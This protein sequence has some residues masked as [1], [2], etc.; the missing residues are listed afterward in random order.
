VLNY[1]LLN[2]AKGRQQI[3]LKFLHHQ[4]KLHHHHQE[5]QQSPPQKPPK[6]GPNN[7]AVPITSLLAALPLAPTSSSR[8]GIRF[9]YLIAF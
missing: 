5:G 9:C 4:P 6:F 2:G 7:P 8:T 1:N 3:C